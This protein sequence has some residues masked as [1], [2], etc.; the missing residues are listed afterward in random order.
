MGIEFS[1]I[2]TK[3]I[4]IS[5]KKDGDDDDG[6]DY[7]GLTLRNSLPNKESQSSLNLTTERGKSSVPK[8]E[9]VIW[10]DADPCPRAASFPPNLRK[11]AP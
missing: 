11:L 3:A 2:P 4:K 7:D 5:K 1:L 8:L 10:L 9:R 6:N